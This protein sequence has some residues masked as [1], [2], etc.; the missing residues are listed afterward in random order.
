MCIGIPMQVMWS[1]E[2]AAFCRLDST[3]EWVDISLVGEQP[4]GTWLLVFLGSARSVLDA[5]TAGKTLAALQALTSVA[6][7]ENRVDHLF[8]DLHQREPWLPEHLRPAAGAASRIASQSS[9]QCAGVN[10]NRIDQSPA[11]G[12]GTDPGAVEQEQKSA[13]FHPRSVNLTRGRQ[14]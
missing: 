3:T 11:Q 8:P 1:K 5:E 14:S 4:E 9:A 13:E 12:P 2:Q 7:G 10:A 6:A